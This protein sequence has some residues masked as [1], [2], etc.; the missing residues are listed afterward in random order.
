M[1]KKL[2]KHIHCTQE[3]CCTIIFAIFEWL[4]PKI[5]FYYRFVL[6]PVNVKMNYSYLF[7]IFIMC[8]N[9]ET[10]NFLPSS[11][12]FK[13]IPNDLCSLDDMQFRCSHYIVSHS[14]KVDTTRNFVLLPFGIAINMKIIFIMNRIE[15]HCYMLHCFEQ[16]TNHSHS[17]KRNK[18]QNQSFFFI[19]RYYYILNLW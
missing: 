2:T 11:I 1:V 3:R 5:D 6:D 9:D 16:L 4:R 17:M 18:N 8:K 19:N 10:T 15:A 7:P 13:S 14:K 12:V